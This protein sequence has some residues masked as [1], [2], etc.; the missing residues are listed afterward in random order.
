MIEIDIPVEEVD[1]PSLFLGSALPHHVG[2]SSSQKL[3]LLACHQTHAIGVNR[4]E[5]K[6]S[7]V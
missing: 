4:M 2:S 3:Y 7:D 5:I 1:C 6:S